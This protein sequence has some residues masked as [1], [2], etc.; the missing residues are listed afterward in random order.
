MWKHN[1][2][3]FPRYVS[4]KKTCVCVFQMYY[5]RIRLLSFRIV[6]PKLNEQTRFSEHCNVGILCGLIA[7]K[8]AIIIPFCFHLM[9]LFI[10]CICFVLFCCSFFR[11]GKS[12]TTV[13]GVIICKFDLSFELSL[14]F[15]W[16][17]MF[18]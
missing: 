2:N 9:M 3:C 18:I 7:S 12:A 17:S 13:C 5:R 15:A 14:L 1:E 8:C 10:I 11:D 16:C 4:M 6:V